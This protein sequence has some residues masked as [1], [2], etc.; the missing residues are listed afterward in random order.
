[1]FTLSVVFALVLLSCSQLI[2]AGTVVTCIDSELYLSCDVG[3]IFVKSVTLGSQS[4]RYCGPAKPQNEIRCFAIPVPAVAKWCNGR[5]ECDVDKQQVIGEDPCF[6]PYTY[7]TTTYTCVPGIA[8]GKEAA[9]YPPP[10][11]FS[12]IHVSAH[13]STCGSP[14]TVHNCG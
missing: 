10:M 12:L 1:M 5:E 8:K 9:Q 2:S 7:Y 11:M 4:T 6:N 3:V 13:A 14:I